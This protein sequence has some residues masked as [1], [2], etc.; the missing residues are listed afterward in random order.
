MELRCRTV[1]AAL[2]FWGQIQ[3][4]MMRVSMSI[5]ILAMA[6]SSGGAD[7]A[8]AASCPAPAEGAGN[9]TSLGQGEEQEGEFD[10]DSVMIGVV[11]SAFNWGYI[12]TQLLGG[13]LA[14]LLGFKVVFRFLSMT[15]Q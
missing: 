13:R 5:I 10:W 6:R 4:Y 15:K 8:G 7:Q 1:L 14:E 2:L 9:T 3:N 12:T 11:L